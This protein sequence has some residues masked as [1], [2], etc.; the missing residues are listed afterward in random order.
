MQPTYKLNVSEHEQLNS[1]ILKLQSPDL[2]SNLSFPP[3]E[4]LL[5]ADTVPVFTVGN[6]VTWN[7][8]R[9]IIEDCLGFTYH[10]EAVQI[11]LASLPGLREGARIVFT[12]SIGIRALRV[13]LASQAF[14]AFHDSIGGME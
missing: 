2:Q 13:H 7:G 11:G 14:Q 1:K 4:G 8:T 5:E 12:G 6:V 3:F 9:G 10:V